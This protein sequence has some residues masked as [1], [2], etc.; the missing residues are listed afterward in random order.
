MC[1][2]VHR[3]LHVFMSICISLDV[4]A[5]CIRYSHDHMPT[6]HAIDTHLSINLCTMMHIVATNYAGALCIVTA[7][8]THAILLM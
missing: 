5:Y 6:D 3:N 2:Y 7:R 4:Y 8:D 1:I